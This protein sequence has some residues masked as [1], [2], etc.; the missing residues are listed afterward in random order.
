MTPEEQMVERA[1]SA[2]KY[3]AERPVQYEMA[4]PPIAMPMH[5]SIDGNTYNVAAEK[6]NGTCFLK[7]YSD[8]MIGG[9]DLAGTIKVSKQ[10]AHCGVAPQVLDYS[11]E[12]NSIL[13][14]HL[15]PDWRPALAK[16]FN[17]IDIR[18]KSIE[19]KLLF[20][21]KGEAANSI[22]LLEV[23]RQFHE[24]LEE[25]TAE[26]A[27]IKKPNGYATMTA[28]IDRIGE[29]LYAAGIPKSPIH[30]ENT[31]SNVM[32]GPDKK[33]KLVDFDRVCQGDPMYD[34][35]AFCMEFCP[36]DYQLIEAVEMY[37]RTFDVRLFNRCKL[38]MILDDFMWGCWGKIAHYT[39]P[40]SKDIEFYKYGEVRFLRC[41]HH[42]NTW[43]VDT[44]TRRI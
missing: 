5:L 25:D 22:M 1:L 7:I 3:L 4:F 19:A 43:D 9:L 44:L 32:I 17:D 35:G 34:L 14:E 16:D 38:Y 2:F 39:S 11:V 21:E 26:G 27:P 12:T 36:F 20:H 18:A 41:L 10:A 33:I 15:G 42:I 24:R 28:W 13:F 30:G 29:A 31:V 37:N 40:R 8:D 23:V 6:P